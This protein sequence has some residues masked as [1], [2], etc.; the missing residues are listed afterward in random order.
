MSNN[1][2]NNI[3]ERQL[4]SL[5]GTDPR[6][7]ILKYINETISRYITQIESASINRAIKDTQIDYSLSDDLDKIGSWFS[8]FRV[9][10]E[11]DELFRN[12][13][14]ALAAAPINPTVDAIQ[15]TYEALIGLRPVI[16]EDFVT[17]VLSSGESIPSDE[18]LAEFTVQ[19]NIDIIKVFET[20]LIN[21]DGESVT[22][23]HTTNIDEPSGFSAWDSVNDPIH[24]TDIS[25]TLDPDTSIM[26]LT[27]GPYSLDTLIDVEYYITPL[28][29]YDT[30]EELTTNLPVM[31]AILQIT[32]AAGTKTGGIQLVKFLQS[33]FQ[34]GGVE[35]L[36]I[37][38]FFLTSQLFNIDEPVPDAYS[39]LWGTARWGMH[40]WGQE[41]TIIDAFSYL[42]IPKDTHLSEIII[43]IPESFHSSEIKIV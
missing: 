3:N 29:S 25:D 30:L 33:W 23:G 10:G 43:W 2:S 8:A 1:T 7:N 40:H 12:R 42:L 22:V 11:T 20:I 31:N 16:K 34:S 24:L 32:K 39:S 6:Y 26:T 37:I 36:A 14:L 35:T 38:D 15:D 5:E 41:G 27:G 18:I 9:Q 28:A 21:A 13:L 4:Y 17:R 19:F